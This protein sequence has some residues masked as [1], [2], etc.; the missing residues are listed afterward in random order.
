MGDLKNL[1]NQ[2]KLQETKDL[3][4]KNK[5]KKFEVLVKQKL[6][7]GLT[8]AQATAEAEQEIFK[9]EKLA[10]IRLNGDKGFGERKKVSFFVANKDLQELKE[11]FKI[12][13]EEGEHIIR[14][15]EVNKILNKLLS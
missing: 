2:E 13:E 10:K 11:K 7:K 3:N 14:N 5:I 1:I 12:I 9:P 8:K 6:A 4:Y 15:I